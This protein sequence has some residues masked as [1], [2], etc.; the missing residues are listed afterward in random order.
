M[1]PSRWVLNHAAA[2]SPQVRGVDRLERRQARAAHRQNS[3]HRKPPGDKMQNELFQLST[4]TMLAILGV[5]YGL[6]IIMSVAITRKKENVNAYM[7]SN[8]NI[9]F[10]LA[11]ASMT[12]TWI[13]AASYYGAATS[14][15]TYGLSGAIHYGLW[16][17]LMLLFIYPFGKR[18][19]ELAPSAHTLAEVMWARHGRA[20]QLALVLS[21]FLGSGLSLT[22]NITASGALVSVLSPL[23]FV[24]GVLIASVA[25]L[26]YT[27]IPGFR[28]SVFTDFV[29]ACSLL[30]GA[31]IVIPIIVFSAG[32]P[33]EL[34]AGLTDI[35]EAQASMFSEQAILEQGAPFF[36][37]VLSYAIGNQTITQRVFSVDPRYIRRTFVTAT[38]GYG[39]IVIGLG[40][41]GLVALLAGLEPL[42]G[43]LNNLLPQMAA[44]YL[45][46]VLVILFALLV[47]ASLSSTADS[48]LAALSSVVMTD[49]YGRNLARGTPS[50]QTMLLLGRLTMVI[51]M[52]GA[53]MLAITEVDI[54]VMLVIAGGL[55]GA[56]VFPVISSVYWPRVTNV[57][58]SVSVLVALVAFATVRF[59]L[60]ALPGSLLYGFEAFS[61][62]GAGVIVGLMTFAFT[63]ARI[64][65][66]VGAIVAVLVA[67]Y[68]WGFVR[69]YVA[70]YAVTISY[71][72][73]TVLCVGISLLSHRHFDFARVDKLVQDFKQG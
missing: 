25:I 47:I 27:L 73:S 13:W 17:A 15:Y 66:I 63:N 72:V 20:S 54:L 67:P 52:I 1:V 4:P 46:A 6:M 28:A 29:A 32:G 59:E 30:L 35:T 48:D 58:F 21:N 2:A 22:V 39:A 70:L 41:L 36:A 12:T 8:R 57:A 49:V 44:M 38:F 60:L 34:A 23:S 33:A 9:G 24:E 65:M 56:I 40:M 10:G 43:S 51:S 11:A 71:G 19:R 61:I 42:Q 14:A 31:V 16:G 7:V 18:F 3:P 68:L 26:A 53:I 5:F 55:W 69:E 37:A 50:A 45:P 62:I 64:G